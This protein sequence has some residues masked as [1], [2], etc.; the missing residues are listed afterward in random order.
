[1]K[2]KKLNKAFSGSLPEWKDTTAGPTASK[3]NQVVPPPPPA[4][5][6]S[7]VPPPPAKS[8]GQPNV[9]L[10]SNGLPM[11]KSN[12][13]PGRNRTIPQKETNSAKQNNKPEKST[14]LPWKAPPSP[15]FVPSEESIRSKPKSGPKGPASNPNGVQKLVDK[16]IETGKDFIAS[17]SENLSP[18]SDSAQNLDSQKTASD[19]KQTGLPRN[20]NAPKVPLPGIDEAPPWK[21]EIEEIDSIKLQHTIQKHKKVYLRALIELVDRNSGVRV[22][23]QWIDALQVK[24]VMEIVQ[25]N[26]PR[27]SKI[28]EIMVGLDEMIIPLQSNISIYI[29][30]G[31]D[32]PKY[33]K[34][35]TLI[36]FSK[37]YEFKLRHIKLAIKSEVEK[38]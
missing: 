1:M 13:A 29:P 21:E 23:V 7:A 8:P 16:A 28:I 18:S 31:E 6:K 10:N 17:V 30:D 11:K 5:K 34:S 26:I 20:E 33:N 32:E 4:R 2:L 27:S 22:H 37:E 12:N 38:R 3:E 14:N 9:E 24:G 35:E 19:A 36:Y 25:I 15:K